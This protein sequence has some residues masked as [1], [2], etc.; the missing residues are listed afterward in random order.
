M[1]QRNDIPGLHVCTLIGVAVGDPRLHSIFFIYYFSLSEK[2]LCWCDALP[3]GRLEVSYIYGTMPIDIG[4]KHTEEVYPM[5]VHN[6][7]QSCHTILA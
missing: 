3:A 2:Y 6:A 5:S 1:P 4:E 7:T